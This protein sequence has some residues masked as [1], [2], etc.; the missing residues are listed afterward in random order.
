MVPPVGLWRGS[1]NDGWGR[2]SDMESTS[3][4][5]FC[6]A[7]LV[8]GLDTSIS[9]LGVFLVASLTGVDREFFVESCGCCGAPG[10]GDTGLVGGRAKRGLLGTLVVMPVSCEGDLDLAL[11]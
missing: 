8:E 3:L 2:S 7:G 1:S 11:A 9:D 10:V 5:F 6:S 4:A